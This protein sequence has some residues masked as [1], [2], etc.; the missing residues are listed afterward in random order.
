VLILIYNTISI[1]LYNDTYLSLVKGKGTMLAYIYKS[2]KFERTS[3]GHIKRRET[4]TP[5]TLAA[6]ALAPSVVPSPQLV[7]ISVPET[8]DEDPQQNESP[9]GSDDQDVPVESPG[10]HSPEERDH[11]VA[12]KKIPARIAT[13]K[14]PA[15]SSL[16][17]GS[18]EKKKGNVY[19]TKK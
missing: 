10:E 6:A 4:L 12:P 8:Q 16:R 15:S 7:D 19:F 2:R 17:K 18:T 1:Y 13:P 11:M 5:P 3:S 9:I 14:K